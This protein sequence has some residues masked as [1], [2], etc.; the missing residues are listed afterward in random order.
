[1]KL[2]A[3]C[4][5]L[6]MALFVGVG[7]GDDDEEA[8][9]VTETVTETEATTGPEKTTTIQTDGGGTQD[10][11]ELENAERNARREASRQLEDQGGGFTVAEADWQVT[12]S[13]GESGGAWSC[14]LSSGPCS[15]T[16]DVVPQGEGVSVTTAK[17]GCAAD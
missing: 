4:A 15:G 13:G 14:K 11:V 17:V 7:C 8:K 16:A 9:T 12:C 1:M 10:K 3:I 2:G 6:A 5:V